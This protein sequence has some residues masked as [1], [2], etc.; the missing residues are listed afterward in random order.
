MPPRQREYPTRCCECGQVK[1]QPDIMAV[2]IAEI[3]HDNVLHR[4]VVENLHVLKCQNC[5][6]ILFDNTS[7]DQISQAERNQLHLLS[8]QQ[9][10]ERLEELGMSVEEFGKKVVE[11]YLNG[12]HIQSKTTDWIMREVLKIESP[13]P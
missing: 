11:K 5:G 3:K 1:V 9:M 13:S 10:M 8:P 4:V 2:Y 7:S 12:G 6:E